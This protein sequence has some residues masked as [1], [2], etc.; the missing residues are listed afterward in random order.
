MKPPLAPELLAA[1]AELAGTLP[2]REGDRS[3]L[4]LLGPG[5]LV[6]VE[7]FAD[8]PAGAGPA[9]RL[10]RGDLL[11][12]RQA[13]YLVVHR[14]LKR[15]RPVAGRP[16][17]RTRGDGSTT[18]DP[19]LDPRRVVGRVTAFRRRETWWSLQSR[20]ARLYA[21]GVATHALGYAAL[22]LGA[23]ATDRLLGRVGLPPLLLPAVRGL[24]RAMLGLAHR[25]SFRLLHRRTQA[26][27]PRRR[28]P[29]G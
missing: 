1:S 10:R 11:L 28:G 6:A 2:I 13:D 14:L 15:A 18:L 29:E 9:V 20:G 25:L 17:L 3:M 24:D 7:Y 5:Q 19:A 22:G 23:A 26:P 16:A 12:F 21:S 4:P 27:A 8:R